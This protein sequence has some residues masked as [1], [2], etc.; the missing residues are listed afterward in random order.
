MKIN[1]ILIGKGSGSAGN[2]T[3]V[4]LKGQTI[5][6]QKA[7]IVANPK[8]PSQMLQRSMMNRAV[9]AWQLFGNV[10]KQGITSIP[11]TQSQYNVYVSEN[12]LHF[13]NSL[14]D[15]ST[16]RNMD[17]IGSLASKGT[18]GTLSPTSVEADAGTIVIEFPPGQLGNLLKVGDKIV[19]LAGITLQEKMVYGEYVLTPADVLPNATGITIPVDNDL[20]DEEGVL[21]IFGVSADNKKSTTQT[22]SAKTIGGR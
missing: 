10:L 5:L 1:S 2:I 20:A 8:T 21:T 11:P 3:V 14:F 15:K 6:K 17:L 22:F 19:I 16:F 9:Y 12:A 7:S 18:L 13:K 4:Q